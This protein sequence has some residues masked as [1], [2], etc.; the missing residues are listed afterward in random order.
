MNNIIILI[1]VLIVCCIIS[2]IIFP[3]KKRI[4]FTFGDLK[5]DTIQL[6]YIPNL[7]TPE[8][9][10]HLISVAKD[11]LKRSCVVNDTKANDYDDNR[12][13]Y[14]F[15]FDKG[16]DDVVKRIENTI[17]SM[18]GVST[19]NI[20]ALQVV[21]YEDGQQFKEHYDWFYKP[22]RN[23]INNQRQ[24]TFFVYLN[25]VHTG[26]ETVFPKLNLSFSPKQGHAL[27]W[28]NCSSFY[29]C[30]D[31]S[32]HQGKPPIGETKYG[33]NIWINFNKIK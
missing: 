28:E 5:N 31:K 14:S 24:Y 8:E 4:I 17:S 13:S 9:C 22:Y 18:L 6:R 21:R 2:L 30:H 29:D 1:L 26:G 27:F 33:L 32:I 20:E 25:D 3:I 23:K 12:T 10:N 7:L 19:D 16:H 15:Y 11:G